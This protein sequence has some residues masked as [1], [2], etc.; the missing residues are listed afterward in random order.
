MLHII[1]ISENLK[2]NKFFHF[3]FKKWWSDN[4]IKKVYVY[5]Y[6]YSYN[7]CDILISFAFHELLN[8]I[9]LKLS[10]NFIL[11]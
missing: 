9:K 1:I 6:I 10:E 5:I 3:F 2:Y 11:H 4:E 8:N 7:I